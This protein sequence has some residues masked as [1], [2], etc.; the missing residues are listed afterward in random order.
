MRTAVPDTCQQYNEACSRL[1]CP[2]GLSRSYGP[3]DGCERCECDDP[4][5]GYICPDDAQCSVDITPD[6]QSGTAFTPICRKGLHILKLLL[7]AH[8]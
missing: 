2:Y 5:R 7:R 4:C 8:H 3:E 1:N 6:P